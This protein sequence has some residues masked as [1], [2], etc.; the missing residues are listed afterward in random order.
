MLHVR[1]NFYLGT[2]III[3]GLSSQ[4][5]WKFRKRFSLWYIS[6]LLI[7]VG[8]PPKSK[9]IFLWLYKLITK[10]HREEEPAYNAVALW[11]NLDQHWKRLVTYPG[12][13]ARVLSRISNAIWNNHFRI[14]MYFQECKARLS[15]VRLTAQPSAL[16]PTQRLDCPWYQR[17][18][19]RMAF[20]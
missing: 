9:I 8:L 15:L 4:R 13:M 12:K 7:S 6:F 17:Q 16:C 5:W 1:H 2:N 18:I 11:K 14:A 19:Q 20:P 3:G 10:W